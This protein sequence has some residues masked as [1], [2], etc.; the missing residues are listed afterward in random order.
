MKSFM[1]CEMQLVISHLIEE[2]LISKD[3]WKGT[4]IRAMILYKTI[5]KPNNLNFTRIPMD[6]P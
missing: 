4:C 6:G 1:D 2:V 3:L 5:L